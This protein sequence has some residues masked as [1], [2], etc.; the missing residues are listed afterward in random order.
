MISCC[1]EQAGEESSKSEITGSLP[2][3]ALA[4][5]RGKDRDRRSVVEIARREKATFTEALVNPKLELPIATY[6]SDR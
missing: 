1:N 5:A 6:C 2:Q 4:R 3:P